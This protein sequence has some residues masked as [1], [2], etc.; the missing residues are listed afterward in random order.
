VALRQQPPRQVLWPTW[1]HERAGGSNAPIAELAR[2]A[3]TDPF[4]L[5]NRSGLPLHRR[6]EK[7]ASKRFAAA[8]C[9]NRASSLAGV[10]PRP[11]L[12]WWL[13]AE[14]DLVLDAIEPRLRTTVGRPIT[15][16]TAA[17]QRRSNNEATAH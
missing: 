11:V 14:L 1:G 13:K 2:L 16:A 3:A 5:L 17:L 10:R 9:G 15:A 8:I 7:A 12:H 4:P 6:G